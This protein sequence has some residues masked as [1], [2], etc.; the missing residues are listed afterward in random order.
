MNVSS[1]KEASNDFYEKIISKALNNE[2]F[3]NRL[4]SKPNETISQVYNGS[5]VFNDLNI[6]VE[7]QSD[8]NMIFLNIPRKPH[9]DSFELTDEELEIVSGGETIVL[10]ICGVIIGI[11]LAIL[12]HQVAHM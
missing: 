7:D 8:S 11:E 6:L 9:Y 10:G 3:K 12:A 2:E 4:I 5:S 1:I